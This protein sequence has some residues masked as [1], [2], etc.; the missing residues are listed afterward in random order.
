M[1]LKTKILGLTLIPLILVLASCGGDG[2]SQ[3]VSG[4]GQGIIAD[5][6]AISGVNS[7]GGGFDDGASID[8]GA[9]IESL[10]ETDVPAH[11]AALNYS[12]VKKLIGCSQ[13]SYRDCKCWDPTNPDQNGTL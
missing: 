1:K 13:S 9:G 5:G 6:S 3:S 10:P 12:Y 7:S 8:G 2:T 4:N 11:C